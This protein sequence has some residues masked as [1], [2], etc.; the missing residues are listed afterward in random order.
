VGA[1]SSHSPVSDVQCEVVHYHVE[2][3]QS[4]S[5]DACHSVH[6]TVFSVSERNEL[7]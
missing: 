5:L 2:G 3:R 1:P 4:F 6:I 7:L